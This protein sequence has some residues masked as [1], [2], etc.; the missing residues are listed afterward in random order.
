MEKHG[1]DH[2]A[3]GC[4]Q[5]TPLRFLGTEEWCIG[6]A[7]PPRD[8]FLPL[9]DEGSVLFWCRI[10]VRESSK[11]TR[12]PSLD[13]CIIPPRHLCGFDSSHPASRGRTITGPGELQQ[14][15]SF[16]CRITSGT[17]LKGVPNVCEGSLNPRSAAAGGRP[18]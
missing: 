5:R 4:R 11:A 15:A 3:F 14:F 9:S 1:S 13:H 2:A 12:C 17:A 8:D 10:S 6:V 7:S 18:D 16:R